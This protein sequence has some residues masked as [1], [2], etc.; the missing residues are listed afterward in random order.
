MTRSFAMASFAADHYQ[1]KGRIRRVYLKH[2]IEVQ[3]FGAKFSQERKYKAKTE[4]AIVRVNSRRGTSEHATIRTGKNCPS[5]QLSAK[6]K[7]DTTFFLRKSVEGLPG[8]AV[9]YII[10]GAHPQLQKKERVEGLDSISEIFREEV[11][12]WSNYQ[13][14]IGRHFADKR[15]DK[16]TQA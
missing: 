6:L 16:R 4:G 1:G 15:G 14:N 9:G 12:R 7:G 2:C 13:A 11:R 3:L 5:S 10:A 8:V